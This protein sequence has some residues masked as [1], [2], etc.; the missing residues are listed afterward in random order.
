MQLIASTFVVLLSTGFNAAIAIAAEPAIENSMESRAPE[1]HAQAP[2]QFS[3]VHVDS[4]SSKASADEITSQSA[5]AS[6]ARVSWFSQVVGRPESRND[7]PT[8]WFHESTLR[9]AF[10]DQL[11][12]PVMGAV[13]TQEW[14][15]NLAHQQV[16][17]PFLGLRGE[18]LWS[19]SLGAT[20]WLARLIGQVEYR[21]RESRA[22]NSIRGADPRALLAGAFWWEIQPQ[23]SSTWALDAYLQVGRAPRF[24]E[25]AFHSEQVRLL[26]RA[27]LGQFAKG[28]HAIDLGIEAFQEVAPSLDLGTDRRELRLGGAWVWVSATHPDTRGLQLRVH[29]AYP[30]LAKS[31]LGQDDSRRRWEATLFFT[32]AWDQGG[33][34]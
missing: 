10:A 26:R 32:W 25:N 11:I 23:A 34:K 5:I 7:R 16:A 15:T 30:I 8:G 13:L 4:S 27:R 29:E 2:T 21:Y 6:K 1:S 22:E 20:Q 17:S 12:T 24:D 3:V 33:A 14:P 9:A 31:Q 18:N 19:D 28:T